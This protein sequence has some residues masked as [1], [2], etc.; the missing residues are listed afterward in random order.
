MKPNRADEKLEWAK[1]YRD[2]MGRF[3]K[4][5]PSMFKGTKL[6]EERRKQ[7]SNVQKGKVLSEDTKR[8]MS[9]KH[10]L[11]GT[12]PPHYSG[13]EH[14]N[15][16][17]DEVGYYGVHVWMQK[18]FGT[19]SKC[20]NCGTEEDTKY[21]WSNNSGNYLRDRTDWQRLCIKCHRVKD[22]WVEKVR[23]TR[24][25]KRLLEAKQHIEYGMRKGFIHEDY[26]LDSMEPQEIIEIADEME[27]RADAAYE[28][29]KERDV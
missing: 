8:K 18:Q 26:A 29:W 15:W 24:Q 28:A 21:N 12:T 6:S 19:P 3:I 10:K 16:K 27:S 2:S 1:T 9:E 20:E 17:G 4:G 11:I 25:A 22:N 5:V 14:Y 13:E 7:I 23:K